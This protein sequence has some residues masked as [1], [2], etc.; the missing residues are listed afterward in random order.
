M[1]IQ[2][3]I[4]SK[5]FVQL[6]KNSPN[7]SEKTPFGRH[8]IN[9]DN[10]IIKINRNVICADTT[11][12]LPYAAEPTSKGL[13]EFTHW[14]QTHGNASAFHFQTEYSGLIGNSEFLW[15]RNQTFDSF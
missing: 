6:L 10:I 12:L 14:Q 15:E 4:F 13:S 8:R 3:V 2:A 9:F 11:L 1:D 7:F 5:H